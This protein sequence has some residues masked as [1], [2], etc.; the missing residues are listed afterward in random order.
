[1]NELA[2]REALIDV[3]TGEVL[4]ATPQNAH[5]ILSRLDEIEAKVRVARAA[6]TA[7]V[8]AE[9]KQ[10]GTKTFDVPG[11]KLVLEG[12][13]TTVVEGNE[14][15][16]LLSEAGMSEE[17]IAEIVQP[18]VTYKVNRAKLKQATAANDDYKA[19]A[20]LVTSTELKPWRAKAR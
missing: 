4:P 3:F 16:Q 6:I 15:A 12:G 18:V 13:P 7:Y 10:Q 11:G 1:M 8:E 14:L 19:A 17:R 20:E 5:S 9:S 2:E